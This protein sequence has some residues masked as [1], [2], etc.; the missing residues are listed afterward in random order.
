M[1][2]QMKIEENRL[3]VKAQLWGKGESSCLNIAISK[4]LKVLTDDRDA[5]KLA[6]KKGVFLFQ[7]PLE[8]WLKR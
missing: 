6:Q 3:A 7:E 5:R 4:D 1:T 2:K 8:F